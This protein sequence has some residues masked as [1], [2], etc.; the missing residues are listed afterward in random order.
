MVMFSRQQD[1]SLSNRNAK[2]LKSS[3]FVLLM[4]LIFSV[5]FS[6]QI[7]FAE[8]EDDETEVTNSKDD[9]GAA[10][11]EKADADSSGMSRQQAMLAGLTIFVLSIFVGFEMITKVPPTLHTPLMSG[12]NAI[13]G[14]TIVGAVIVA[15]SATGFAWFVGIL[16][17][18]LAAVNVIG[19]FMVTHRMLAMFKR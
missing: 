6:P 13:S 15:G 2:R 16:A 3:L 8:G 11:E 18:I 7:A 9:E 4:S 19:G 10:E 5:S 12:S 1:S 14:I 17:V